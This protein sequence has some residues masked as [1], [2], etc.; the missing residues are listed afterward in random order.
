LKKL[1]QPQK[2]P[3]SGA[4]LFRRVGKIG[5]KKSDHFTYTYAFP[6]LR[7]WLVGQIPPRQRIL[8]V[9]CGT[10]ELEKV[11][12]TQARLVVGIDLFIE[13]LHRAGRR[14][15]QHLVQTNTHWLPFASRC[16]DAVILPETL[17]Y[18]DPDK[19]L[20]EAA[21]VLK[22]NGR[23]L[24]TTYPVHLV[25]HS[26]YKKRSA[27]EVSLALGRTGFSVVERRFLLLKRFGLQEVKEENRCSLLYLLARKQG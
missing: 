13:M 27:E 7:R 15:I 22:K 24:I 8:S 10:G 4:T 14:G 23:L 17:G 2:T 20:R 3:R 25:A 6:S 18:V 5:W 26:V 11:L 19:T 16:F 1:A 9:G 12:A 21:R